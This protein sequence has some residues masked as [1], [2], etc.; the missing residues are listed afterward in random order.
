M[1]AD[2]IRSKITGGINCKK[3]GYAKIFDRY[4]SRFR[5]VTPEG[6]D[7]ADEFRS[8]QAAMIAGANAPEG[9]DIRA[10]LLSTDCN[11]RRYIEIKNAFKRCLNGSYHQYEPVEHPSRCDGIHRVPAQEF[12]SPVPCRVG[13]SKPSSIYL[14]R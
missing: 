10:L 4:G 2:G 5:K 9:T 7:A 14:R 13:S 3:V 6:K 12:R 1:G 8:L 11:L